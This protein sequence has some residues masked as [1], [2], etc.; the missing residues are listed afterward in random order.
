MILVGLGVRVRFRARIRV[1]HKRCCPCLLCLSVPGSSF[2]NDISR[3]DKMVYLLYT[4]IIYI[5]LEVQPG[6]KFEL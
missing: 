4:I 1:R 3:G 2:L 5:L 6:W